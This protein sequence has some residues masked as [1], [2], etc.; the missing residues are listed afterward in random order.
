VAR[1]EKEEETRYLQRHLPV[2]YLLWLGPYLLKF[3]PPAVSQ[4]S[5]YEI[6]RAIFKFKP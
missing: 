4:H 1:K 5:T 6:V 2:T 3:P